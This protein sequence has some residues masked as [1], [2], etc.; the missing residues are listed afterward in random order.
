MMFMNRLALCAGAAGCTLLAGSIASAE[1]TL[2]VPSAGVHRD[3]SRHLSVSDFSLQRTDFAGRLGDPLRVELNIDGVEHEFSLS[4]FSVRSADFKVMVQVEGGAI[5][6]IEAPAPR[7][8]RGA[9]QDGSMVIVGSLLEYGFNGK[10]VTQGEEP[11]AWG[12]QPLVELVPGSEADLYVMH[13][14]SD[15]LPT[16]HSCGGALSGDEH[17]DGF[18][19]RVETSGAAPRG[20]QLLACELIIDA[21]WHFYNNDNGASVPATVAD[22]E[23]IMAGVDTVYVRDV[24]VTFILNQILVRTDLGTNPYTSN[25]AG[26]LLDQVRNAWVGTGADRDLVHMFTGRNISGGTIGIAWLSA[27]CSNNLGYG[28]SESKFTNSF[29]SRVALTAHEIGHNFSAQHCSGGS[30]YIMCAGLGGCGGIS[31][32]GVTGAGFGNGS[33]NSI[34]NY[35]AGRPCIEP[36][37]PPFLDWPFFQD[38]ASTTLDADVWQSIDGAIVNTGAS[39]EPSG[40][41][42]LNLDFD[43]VIETGRFDLSDDT[44]E[45]LILSLYTQHRGVE[46]GE[47]LFLE[48]FSIAQTWQSLAEFTS[49]GVTQN[50]FEYTEVVLPFLAMWSEVKFRLR[51]SGDGGN[52]D[53]YIDDIAIDTY[54]GLNVPFEDDYESGLDTSFVYE[55]NSGGIISTAADNEPSGSNSLN[56]DNADSIATFNINMSGLFGTDHWVRYYTQRKG[57]E[58]GESLIVEYRTLGDTWN[59]LETVASDGTSQTEFDLHQILVPVVG[60]TN[61]F[62]VRFTATGN[63]GNDDWY[64]DDLAVTTEFIVV[65][66]DEGCNAA[67]LAEPFDSLDFSDIIAFLTAF[68]T[69]EPEADLAAPFGSCDF[70]DVIEFL[71]AFGAGC[72]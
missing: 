60:Y 14:T 54:G 5:V 34:S 65:E 43:D 70:S 49:D 10:I 21:D 29:N 72:P 40:P 22:V 50:D 28:L 63:A 46:A 3:V 37:G 38:F 35:A 51:A 69:C 58:A 67:D 33:I 4:P 61:D 45:T 13:D 41:N 17:A 62:A 56:L 57:V 59:L 66:P 31:P 24:D 32:P 39:N 26:T 55:T 6:E 16:G 71:G 20:G 2:V 27:V 9:S 42:S 64:I 23:N 53:W 30:C 25:S 19:P 44:D 8:Y 1:P 68:S 52:D 12:I 7:T 15:A 48:Y 36:A 18:D 11:R 47:S